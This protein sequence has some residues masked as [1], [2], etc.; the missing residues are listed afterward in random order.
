VS[1][2]IVRSA[3]GTSTVI[4]GVVSMTDV[5]RFVNCVY[6]PST[7]SSTQ[8]SSRSLV[9]HGCGDNRSCVNQSGPRET[10]VARVAAVMFEFTCHVIN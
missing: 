1:I 2:P 8:V 7:V 10:V 5:R 4:L 9:F 6:I 3:G